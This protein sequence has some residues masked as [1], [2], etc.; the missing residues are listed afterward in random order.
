MSGGMLCMGDRPSGESAAAGVGFFFTVAAVGGSGTAAAAAAVPASRLAGRQ[1][2][3]LLF[4]MELGVLRVVPGRVRAEG[5]PVR[6]RQRQSVRSPLLLLPL[7]P[8]PLPLPL[9]LLPPR[10][11][12]PLLALQLLEGAVPGRGA[13]LAQ[14]VAP[15]AAG[16]GVPA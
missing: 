9:L 15:A 1:A 10:L 2:G 11:R 12:R 7:F 3:R 14:A 6:V 8:S 5:P 13:M 4:D 16:P